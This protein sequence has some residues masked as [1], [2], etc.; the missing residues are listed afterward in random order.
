MVPRHL[1]PKISLA[2]L[3]TVVK[4]MTILKICQF[5]GKITVAR[6]YNIFK[7][8]IPIW[9]NFEGSCNVRCSFGWS[10]TFGI[11]FFVLVSFSKKNL[12]TPVK[13]CPITHQPKSSFVKS[14]PGPGWRSSAWPPSRRSWCRP[15]S[16]RRR[17]CGRKTFVSFWAPRCLSRQMPTQKEVALCFCF[18]SF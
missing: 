5:K 10:Y 8:K 11:F 2:H 15:A 12:S 4:K 13:I 6:W 7:P 17:T 3:S 14:I 9:I 1:T 16:E 18:L